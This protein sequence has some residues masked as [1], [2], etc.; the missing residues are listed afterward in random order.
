MNNESK[1]TP[2]RWYASRYVYGPE[3]RPSNEKLRSHSAAVLS[4]EGTEAIAYGDSYD[5]AAATAALLARAPELLAKVE[6]L[7]ALN[8]EMLE[9]LR[10]C[11]ERLL[12]DG[13]DEGNPR[14]IQARAAIA[15]AE[16]T[17]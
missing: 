3:G 12:L 4:D 6:R 13:Y 14:V 5:E 15:K 1:H 7:Q 9:A 17:S 10:E 16:Q 2:G 11:L 8:A